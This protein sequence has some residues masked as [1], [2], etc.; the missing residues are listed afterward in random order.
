MSDEV[1]C[2]GVNRLVPVEDIE[3]ISGR[4]IYLPGRVDCDTGEPLDDD[5]IALTVLSL[6]QTTN[7]Q[8]VS[9]IGTLLSGSGRERIANI[10]NKVEK[11]V[12]D[13][14]KAAS[15]LPD[16]VRNILKDID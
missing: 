6:S 9:M 1:F 7:E 2:E 11:P 5:V 8:N 15:K 10:L 12:R 14:I 16:D 4:R 13:K 3:T